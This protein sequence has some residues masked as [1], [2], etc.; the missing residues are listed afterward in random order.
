MY[1]IK[2]VSC[3]DETKKSESTGI[4]EEDNHGASDPED[5]N[6]DL[7]DEKDD[8][9]EENLDAADLSSLDMDELLNMMTGIVSNADH[10]FDREE[11]F[12]RVKFNEKAFFEVLKEV[13]KMYKGFSDEDAW[14]MHSNMEFSLAWVQTVSCNERQNLENFRV[15]TS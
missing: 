15:G 14:K 12:R 3:D 8:S 6:L 7:L 10:E 5:L 13:Y 1:K 9:D 4:A 2:V 11:V